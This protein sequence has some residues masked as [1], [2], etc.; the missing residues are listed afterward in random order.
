MAVAGSGKAGGEGNGDGAGYEGGVNGG[1]M[2][3][4]VVN[5]GGAQWDQVMPVS[6]PALLSALRTRIGVPTASRPIAVKIAD[7]AAQKNPAEQPPIIYMSFD[8]SGYRFSS[9]DVRWL[10]K[11]TATFGG[12]ILVDDISGGRPH[13]ESLARLVFPG[14]PLVAIPKDDPLFRSRIQM[15]EQDRALTAHGGQSILGVKD[16]GRWV[17]VYHPG[18]LV[19]GWR[20]AYGDRWQES[21]FQFGINAWDYATK[22]FTRR[23]RASAR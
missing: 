3:F 13:A 19:D 8:G 23:L 7:L 12:M 1:K 10:A 18:D 14:K 21:A 5:H 2:Q 15:A 20:R 22:N 16:Q 4:V 17:M 9:E 6:A 11:Y